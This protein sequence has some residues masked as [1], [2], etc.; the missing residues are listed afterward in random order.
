MKIVP[1]FI[2]DDR[3]WKIVAAF[4]EGSAWSEDA[5]GKRIPY[6]CAVPWDSRRKR[7]KTE[8]CEVVFPYFL[9]GIDVSASSRPLDAMKKKP[10]KDT[11]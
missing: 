1:T 7:W 11:K 2:F 3:L 8:R 9:A 5:D 10:G 6:L 4:P